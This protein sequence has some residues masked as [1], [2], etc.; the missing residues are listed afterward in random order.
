MAIKY[1]IT[2]E[3]AHKYV[4]VTENYFF[5]EKYIHYSLTENTLRPYDINNKNPFDCQK[6]VSNQSLFLCCLLPACVS[7]TL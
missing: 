6:I 3:V 5:H 7:I 2:L 4:F 1:A